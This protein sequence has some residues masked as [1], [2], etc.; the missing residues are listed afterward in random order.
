MKSRAIISAS[1]ARAIDGERGVA[2]L[3]TLVLVLALIPVAAAVT[4]QTQLDGLMQRNHLGSVEAFYA[5]DAGLAHAH[6]EIPPMASLRSL[7]DGPDGIPGSTDDG[8]FPFRAMPPSELSYNVRIGPHGSNEVRLRSTGRGRHGAVRELELIVKPSDTP[9]TPAALYVEAPDLALDLRNPE[10]SISGELE[11][12]SRGRAGMAALAVTSAAAAAGARAVDGAPDVFTTAALN[13]DPYAH[14]LRARVDAIIHSPE[15]APARLGTA[16]APQLTIIDGNWRAAGDISAFGIVVVRGD[17]EID[18]RVH[19]GG[20]VVVEGDL[21]LGDAGE[22]RIE[23]AVW[24]HGSATARIELR[25]AGF[26]RYEAS[27]LARTAAALEGALLH[28][29]EIVGWREVS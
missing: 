29:P 22:L 19:C 2:L 8:L 15:S 23:G 1:T 9:F 21:R 16:A 3:A 11:D 18:G 6:A 13:L 12:E 5:A 10:F 14:A 20:L 24:I 28:S 25:G 26:V 7:L 27:N 4:I 17:M